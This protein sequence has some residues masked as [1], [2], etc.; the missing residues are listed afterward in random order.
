MQVKPVKPIPHGEEA[1]PGPGS[2]QSGDTTRHG[3]NLDWDASNHTHKSAFKGSAHKLH[4]LGNLESP[5]A[6]KY[7]LVSIVLQLNLRLNCT[8]Y[9]WPFFLPT[10]VRSLGSS[11]EQSSQSHTLKSGPVLVCWEISKSL[12]YNCRCIPGGSSGIL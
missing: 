7:N 11:S 8:R 4:L 12:A 10:L 6:T 2:Y 9:S 3:Q 5:A 1:T